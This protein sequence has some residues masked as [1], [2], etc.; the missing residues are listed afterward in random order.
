[1]VPKDLPEEVRFETASMPQLGL[2]GYEPA[3]HQKM[4]NHHYFDLKRVFVEGWVP[5]M[6]FAH[7]K[8]S[9]HGWPRRWRGGGGNLW[10]IIWQSCGRNG[11]TKRGLLRGSMLVLSGE[12]GTKAMICSKSV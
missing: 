12:F 11:G 9:L 1:M 7:N 6:P 3:N 2:A 4:F 8:R 5:D 10:S